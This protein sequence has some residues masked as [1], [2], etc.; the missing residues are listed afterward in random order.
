[1]LLKDAL[2]KDFDPRLLSFAEGRRELTRNDPLLF[3]AIYAPHHLKGDNA[4]LPVDSITLCDFHLDL[5]SWARTWTN[6][7]GKRKENRA[8]FI[9]PRNSGKST[10]IFTLLPLWAGAHGH[11]KFVAAFSDSETQAIGHLHTFKQE[12][13]TN[14]LLRQ[15]FPE[16]TEP[17][18]V[19][20]AGR[21]LM[22]NRNQIQQASGFVFMSKGADSAALGMKVGQIRPDVLLFDDIE[23]GESNYSPYEAAKRRETLVSDLFPLNDWAVVGIV[24]TTTM[25]NSLIDQIRKV[26]AAR[27][28]YEGS[29]QLFREAL[30]PELRWI[31]DENIVPHYWPV[32]TEVDG[33][34][35]S[36]WPERWPMEELEKDRHTRGFAKNMMNRPVS[37]DGGYWTDDDIEVDQPVG[38]WGNTILCVDPAVTTA[39]RSD[40][41]GLAVISRGPDGKIYVRHAEQVKLGSDKL[42]E[43]VEE[44]VQSY[45]VGVVYIE[46]NQGGDLWKQV[47]KD[48]S[49]R[50]RTMRNSTNKEVRIAQACDFYKK[51]KVLH[52]KFFPTLEEQMLAFPKVPHDDLVDAVASGVLYFMRS[53][54]VRVSTQQFTYQEV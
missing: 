48:L 22:H 25:P 31:V 21:A 29:E 32:I 51:G 44:L 28:E 49:C 27:D 7:A 3:A 20:N 47:F 4:D 24:G 2:R 30:D 50:V 14:E 38:E 53:T 33:V 10:W 39:K 54:G 1:M 13:E 16:F 6:P 45:N 37:L 46:T 41:T 5:L 34:E 36:L 8:C 43:K 18:R 15:D 35:H 12:L 23:P 52:T 42:R 9:A 11:R 17:R 19:G 26:G 40:Y